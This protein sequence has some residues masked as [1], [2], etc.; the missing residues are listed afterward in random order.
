MHWAS[1][2]FEMTALMTCKSVNSVVKVTKHADDSFFAEAFDPAQTSSVSPNKWCYPGFVAPFQPVHI[3]QRLPG[4]GAS[5]ILV[6]ID[7]PSQGKFLV[8]K[9]AV[10]ELHC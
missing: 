6:S 8:L 7:A 1:S 10:C 9:G 3:C 5:T 2:S 4:V